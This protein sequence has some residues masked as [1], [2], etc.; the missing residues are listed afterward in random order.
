MTTATSTRIF[1]FSAGPAVLP[2]PVLQQAQQDIWNI[3]DSGVG[4]MEHSHR[5]KVFDAVIQEAEADCRAI[6]N[7]SD[8]YAVL[9]LQGGATT[10]FATLPMN[11]LHEGRTADYADTGV[12]TTKAIK[13][14]KLFGNVNVAFDGS[15]S[16]YDHTPADN[17]LSLTD[18]AAYFHYCSNN[19]IYGTR[20]EHVPATSAPIICDASSEM[21]SRPVDITK[22]AV[23]YAGAQKN[24]GPAGCTLVIMRKD[25]MDTAKKPLPVMFDYAKHASKGSCLN[26]PPT[27]AIYII[28]QVFKWILN[29]GGLTGIQALNERKAKIVYDA[30]D[31]SDFYQAVARD[32]CRSRMNIPFRTPNDDLDKKFV[33][34]ALDA[35]MSGLKGHRDVGGLRASIY[36]AFPIEGC[37]ALAEFMKDFENKNG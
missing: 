17:E 36:N 34:E 3:R 30:I 21:F 2:E 33:A 5:G 9:F 13:E 18:G 32:D 28:G 15:A 14:A 31:G 37:H 4:I 11:F 26:T 23:I 22:H 8:D 7:I 19:T 12:W 1:N 25:F 20:Y 29:N 6:A 27:F 24:L 35:G 16:K 10:Q